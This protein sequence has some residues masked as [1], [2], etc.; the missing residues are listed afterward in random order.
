MS[1]WFD[2]YNRRDTCLRVELSHLQIGHLFLLQERGNPLAIGGTNTDISLDDLSDAVSICSNDW[3]QSRCYAW[4]FLANAKFFLWGLLCRKL[5]P[6]T[7]L[8]K[9]D[10]YISHHLQKIKAYTIHGP[11]GA[12]GVCNSP[13]EWLLLTSMISEFKMSRDEALSTPVREAIRLRISR[14]ELDGRVKVKSQEDKEISD[15]NRFETKAGT[16]GPTY[17]PSN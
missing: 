5:D 4:E 9:W 16:N 17:K 2:D 6:V 15:L 7:E 14:S 11:N 13:F 12:P 8:E 3:K 1:E 10:S